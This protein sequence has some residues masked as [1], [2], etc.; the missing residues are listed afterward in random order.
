[1]LLGAG[2]QLFRS[3]SC[4]SREKRDG[5]MV[6]FGKGWPV[7]G[8]MIVV[9]KRPARFSWLGTVKNELKPRLMRV[10]S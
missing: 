8:S 9:E 2:Y 3:A 4:A 5:G 10:P 7:S 6:L 1:M